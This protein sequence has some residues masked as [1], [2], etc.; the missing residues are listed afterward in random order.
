VA[1]WWRLTELTVCYRTPAEIM[2]LAGRLLASIDP[3]LP[4]PRAVRAGGAP[5]WREQVPPGPLPVELDTTPV[6]HERLRP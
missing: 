5:P 1:D 6:D 2:A 4:A 3:A